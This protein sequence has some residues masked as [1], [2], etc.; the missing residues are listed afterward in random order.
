[1]AGIKISDLPSVVT[2]DLTDVFPIDQGAVTYKES[3]SQ[4]LSLFQANGEALTKVDDTNVTMALSGSPSTALLN[5]TAMT[6]GWTGQLAVPRGG[7][8]NSTFTP[9]SVICAGTTATGAF[10]NVVG[11]G[12]AGEQLTSNGP[13]LLPTW[14]AGT[15]S[16]LTTK[17]DLYT[18][19][20]VNARLPVGTV[21]G[22][23]LQVNSGTATGL[24]WSTA[25]YP[26]TALNVAR[27]LRS[28]GTNYVDTTSTFAD[29]YAASGFL[30]ANGANNVA[31]LATANN[32][33]PVTNNTGVPSILAG[34]GTTG[35]I[36]QSNAAAAPSWS[37][38]TYPSTAGSSGNVLTSDGTNWSS[39]APAA[40][41]TSVI[42]DD[43][44]TNATMYP[45]WVTAS[46]GSL[47][48]K[49]TSTK[50]SF[51]PSTGTMTLTGSLSSSTGVTSSAGLN[52]LTY[53]YTGSAVNYFNIINNAT[54]TGP[55]L[56]ATGSDST[57]PF[58]LGAKNAQFIFHD[59][60]STIS[61]KIQLNN[62]ASTN[63]TA[64][65]V[66]T[67]QATNLTLTLPAADAAA[68]NAPMVSNAAGVLSFL[69]QAAITKVNIQTFTS[70]GTYTPT[71][72]MKYCIIE[73]IGSGAGGGGSANQVTGGTAG[74]GGGAGSYARLNA[75]AATIGA[76]QAVTVGNAGTGGAAGTND[77]TDGS[78]VSVGSLCIGKGGSKGTGA[79]S[80]NVGLGGAGGVAGTGDFTVAGQNGGSAVNSISNSQV[81]MSGVGGMGYFGG[82][83]GV[84]VNT[85]G[86][87]VTGTTPSGYGCGGNGG[88]V[89][90]NGGAAAG[91]NG[92]K[93]VVV[94][95]EYIS[96]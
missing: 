89:F 33:V 25:T 59:R 41:A 11:V 69:T 65:T 63:F 90:A 81:P 68:A 83:A 77:G 38:A 53:T 18:F 26:S 5:A 21:N 87:P 4:L 78:D 91:G 32:G 47:P 44:T 58:L 42:V 49:V 96:V 19:T 93:G 28:D 45:T 13:G 10:Q 62:A 52:L 7:T 75:T 9:Y 40:S 43:T 24:A 73:A 71:A 2:P 61:G 82:G 46:S 29:T 30:Y 92:Q 55:L 48:L 34:P 14:Q 74:G 67:A 6:L 56:E 36:L 20:T 1:M 60:S 17:G 35:N 15:V 51:N 3:A 23:I 50:L 57:V 22:Q 84:Q 37:T 66:A 94:I 64:L 54:G 88:V 72:G 12:V 80:G 95:T 85:N 8:G 86:T 16:P 39:A 76:S 79:A 70:S 27:I 31:G